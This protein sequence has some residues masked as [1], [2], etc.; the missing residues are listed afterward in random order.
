MINIEKIFPIRNFSIFFIVIFKMF[1]YVYFILW[2]CWIIVA[3]CEV[4]SSCSKWKLPYRCHA[5]AS[6][7]G[8]FSYQ[9]GVVGCVGFRGCHTWAQQLWF[10]GS[11]A[12]AQQ[13]WCRGLISLLH[14][15]SFCSRVQTHV[16]HQQADSLPL[17]H[18][19]SPY[20]NFYRII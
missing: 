18:Q 1:L 14:E 8:G 13:L 4:F 3:A 17:S 11:G 7:F 2:L 16:S 19:G 5:P 10:L 12:L 6:H 9:S 20:C 15:G